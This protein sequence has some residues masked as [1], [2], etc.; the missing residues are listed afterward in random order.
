L[1]SA[2]LKTPQCPMP[3]SYSFVTTNQVKILKGDIMAEEQKE[4]QRQKFAESRLTLINRNNLALTGV[5]KVIGANE[6]CVHLIVSGDRVCIEGN[7][8]HVSKLDVEQGVIVLDGV[9]NTIKY[10]QH[11][12]PLL[13]RMFK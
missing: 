10:G 11:K 5:E 6:N 9:V 3:T 8:L 4:Q 7:D 2:V 13:K 1:L 12:T